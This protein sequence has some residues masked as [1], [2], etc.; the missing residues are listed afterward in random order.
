MKNFNIIRQ[1]CL[2]ALFA[3]LYFQGSAQTNFKSLNYLYRISGSKTVAGIHNRE[4]NANPCHFF[5]NK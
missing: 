1:C 4:P 5:I 2:T 3:V